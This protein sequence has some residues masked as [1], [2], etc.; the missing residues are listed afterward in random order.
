MRGLFCRA[1]SAQGT[2]GRYIGSDLHQEP[3]GSVATMVPRATV[4]GVSVDTVTEPDLLAAVENVVA[5]DT[6]T[7]FVGLY[8][9]LFRTIAQDDTYRDLVARSTTYPDGQGVVTELHKRG[10]D[11]AER[12]AT[13]DVV[14]PIARL[15]ASRQW[16]VGLYGAAPGVADRAAAAL[17]ISAPGIEVV[18]VWDG[19]SRGPSSTE[20][21]Q[22]RLDVLFVGLGAGRQEAWAYDVA[23]P[24]GV[25][26]ILTSGG[27][28]DFLAGDKRRAPQW[29]QRFGL[30]WAF[31]VLLEPRRLLSRYVLGNSYFLRRARTDRSAVLASD[32]GLAY[33]PT[34]EGTDFAPISGRGAA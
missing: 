25:P 21:A 33:L 2:D 4:L 1:V 5:N 11:D 20:L 28:F 18:A 8:A 14:H 26:A 6:P 9:S 29:M 16:R 7:V 24:A 19:Y 30:E 22:A 32:R 34:N 13:T 27:L 15:A 10:V 31:R 17:A 12:L 23:V 3:A